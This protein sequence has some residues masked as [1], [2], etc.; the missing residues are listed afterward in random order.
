MSGH[1]YTCLTRIEKFFSSQKRVGSL[2]FR[3]L[4]NEVTRLV[5]EAFSD[6]WLIRDYRKALGRLI[7]EWDDRPWQQRRRLAL[8]Y[9]YAS[10]WEGQY[11]EAGPVS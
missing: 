3:P 11:R 5:L 2:K 10:R 9:R 7:D 8:S 1:N 6:P 4:E